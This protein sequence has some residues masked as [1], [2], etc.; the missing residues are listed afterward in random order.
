MNKNN[1]KEIQALAV[2]YRATPLGGSR[3][4]EWVDKYAHSAQY[5]LST[6]S[7]FYA[8]WSDD[9]AKA[10]KECIKQMLADQGSGLYIL[11]AS[12]WA[13]SVGYVVREGALVIITKNNRYI[14]RVSPDYMR[15]YSY[16]WPEWRTKSDVR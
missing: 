11:S 9:K 2:K 8:T 7:D 4:D 13:F 10:F 6:L 12:N 1:K 3:A 14:V 15:N 16:I 5:D